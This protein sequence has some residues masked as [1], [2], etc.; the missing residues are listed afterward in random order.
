MLVKKG[1]CWMLA[2]TADQCGQNPGHTYIPTYIHTY[3]HTY[4]YVHTHVCTYIRIN[5]AI[6]KVELS[7]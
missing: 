6:E 7:G 4:M 5:R 1:E 3:I 2:T